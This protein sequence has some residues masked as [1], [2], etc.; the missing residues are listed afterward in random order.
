MSKPSP[1]K[2]WPK[3][4]WSTYLQFLYG[5]KDFQGSYITFD[6]LN[7]MNFF[8]ATMKT[9]EKQLQ[10]LKIFKTHDNCNY[11]NRGLN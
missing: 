10:I 3:S 4:L 11:P 5:G 8:D 9:N 6:I 2:D 1:G 7:N